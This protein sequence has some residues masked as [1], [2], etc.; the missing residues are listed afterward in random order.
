M[1]DITQLPYFR[2]CPS[3]YHAEVSVLRDASIAAEWTE[4]YRNVLAQASSRS[5]WA[6]FG[7][8]QDSAI[9]ADVTSVLE[10][11][12][13]ILAKKGDSACNGYHPWG[14]L[15]HFSNMFMNSLQPCLLQNSFTQ[16]ALRFLTSGLED[17]YW[18][19][20]VKSSFKL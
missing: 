3:L 14:Y 4:Y 9:K 13:D 10:A 6:F 8:A 18:V 11:L 2:V 17:S 19:I 12:Y 20:N 5:V 1:Q 7:S 15:W 16:M